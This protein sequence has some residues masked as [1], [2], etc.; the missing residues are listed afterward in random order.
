MTVNVSTTL[1]S[2]VISVGRV[3]DRIGTAGIVFLLLLPLVILLLI[4]VPIFLFRGYKKGL[5]L[6]LV[7]LG[8][9][10]VSYVTAVLLSKPVAALISRA[11]F[12]AVTASTD[13][14]TGEAI[15]NSSYMSSFG[16]G[17]LTAVVAMP[18]F[19]VLFILLLLL[20]KIILGACLKNKLQAGEDEKGM[21][22]GGMG[23]RIVDA[24]LLAFLVFV[25]FYAL[26]GSSAAAMG[27]I[28]SELTNGPYEQIELNEPE[29]F[30]RSVNAMDDASKAIGD[31]FAVKVSGRSFI[32]FSYR[33]LAGFRCEGESYN[34]YEILEDSSKIAADGLPL[35]LKKPEAYGSYEKDKIDSIVDHLT[36]N[37]YYGGLI[38]DAAADFE[39]LAD[40]KD[41]GESSVVRASMNKIKNSSIDDVNEAIRSLGNSLKALIDK[42]ALKELTPESLAEA[43]KDKALMTKIDENLRSSEMLSR[44]TDY[45]LGEIFKRLKEQE[46]KDETS[47]KRLSEICDR[48]LDR[49]DENRVD[50][51]DEIKLESE[52]FVHFIS[53]YTDL[54]KDLG[55]IGNMKITEMNTDAFSELFVGLA[56]HPY[57]TEEQAGDMLGLILPMLGTQAK[58]IFTDSLIA[59]VKQTVAQDAQSIRE[60]TA[61]EPVRLKNLLYSSKLMALA[62]EKMNANDAASRDELEGMVGELL[63]G[64][65]ADSAKVIKSAITKEVIEKLGGTQENNEKI[66]GFVTNLVDRMGGVSGSSSEDKKAIT[67]LS[68]LVMKAASTFE[69]G[70]SFEEAVGGS[71][72]S[73]ISLISSSDVMMDTVRDTVTQNGMKPD[74]TGGFRQLSA[75]DKELIV[76]ICRQLVKEGKLSSE[77]MTLIL[78]FFGIDA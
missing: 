39:N 11:I 27:S 17:L 37:R 71:A 24:V 28:S 19:L 57:V 22:F 12:R 52:A 67:E 6:S 4:L 45:A 2:I 5:F 15:A 49:I 40:S 43:L 1:E 63:D 65:T 68:S 72:Q 66:S 14:T 54:S 33:Y 73:F 23:V 47:G 55:D 41:S 56:L 18:I 32:G 75:A 69:E 61:E 38:L 20:T 34:A 53:G 16:K 48:I 31:M 62:I 59:S 46:Y 70:K 10:V 35:M 51:R 36:G 7:S 3:I 26:V 21:K 60:G 44:L 64:M 74:P 8:A 77:D 78:T 13:G 9:T 76:S 50:D 42:K 58:A 25:P 30:R 29:T